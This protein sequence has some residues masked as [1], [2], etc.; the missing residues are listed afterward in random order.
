M[1][2]ISD[3]RII[4]DNIKTLDKIGYLYFFSNGTIS[5][6]MGIGG[7]TLSVPYLSFIINDIKKSIATA[8][9]IGLIIAITSLIYMFILNASI[10]T[11]KLNHL[12][13]LIL[14]PSSILGSYTGVYLLKIIDPEKVKNIFSALLIVV[15][16]YLLID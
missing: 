4:K 11:E 7:G 12:S 14:I 13:L 3:A 10:Y 15:A 16:F 1:L 2:L 6:L 5:S 9:A 8:S